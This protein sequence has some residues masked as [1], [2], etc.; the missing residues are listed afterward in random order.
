MSRSVLLETFDENAEETLMKK[1]NDES[2]QAFTVWQPPLD[3]AVG[4]GSI[5]QT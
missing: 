2:L 5:C 3:D 4:T 1:L